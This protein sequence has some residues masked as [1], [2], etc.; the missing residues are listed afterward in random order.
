[1]KAVISILIFVAATISVHAQMPP[2]SMKTD[3]TVSLY[4]SSSTQE[5]VLQNGQ[6][7]PHYFTVIIYNIAGHPMGEFKIECLPNKDTMLPTEL[8]SGI[9]IITLTDRNFSM[10]RK[11]IIQ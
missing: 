2:D 1:M 11:I 9:Y 3:G 10:T 8:R 6:K 7:M 4:Y 5:L